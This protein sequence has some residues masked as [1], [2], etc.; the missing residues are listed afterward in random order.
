MQHREAR[1]GGRVLRVQRD[2]APVEL[3][4]LVHVRLPPV[5]HALTSAQEAFVGLDGRRPAM[6][7]APLARLEC[8]T[9]Q[10]AGDGLGDFVL[11]REHIGGRALEFLRPLVITGG[12]VDELHRDAQAIAGLAHAAFEHA[13]DAQLR[14]DL[15]QVVAAAKLE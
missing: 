8:A 11:H 10:Q 13:A 3:A 9:A 6:Q 4:R 2:G 5:V 12:G 15:A 7:R 14:A 1:P